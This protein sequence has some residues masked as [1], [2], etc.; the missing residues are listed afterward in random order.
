MM[1]DLDKV[2]AVIRSCTNSAHNQV[3]FA[4]VQNYERKWKHK[5]SAVYLYDLC[6]NNL[7]HLTTYF[8]ETV[9]RSI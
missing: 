3:A 7:I 1:E 8:K 9:C 4:M 5:P 2:R 6:D